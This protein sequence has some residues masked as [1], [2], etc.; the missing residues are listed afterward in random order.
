[1]SNDFLPGRALSAR[2]QTWVFVGVGGVSMCS[3]C[4]LAQRDGAHVVGSDRVPSAAT[5]HLRSL[6]I[7][8]YIGHSEENVPPDADAL[9]YSLAIPP[10]APERQAARRL[11][12]PEWS[13]AQFFGAYM[14]RFAERIGVSGTHGKSTVTAMLHHVFSCAGRSPTTLCGTEV[15]DPF[16]CCCGDDQY[17]IYEGCEYREALL[18]FCPTT[19]VLLNAEWDHPDCFADAQALVS[20]FLRAAEAAGRVVLSVDDRSLRAI[21][22]TMPSRAWTFGQSSDARL[23]YDVIGHTRGC[24][25]VDVTENGTHLGEIQLAVPGRFQC[26]NAAAAV[27]AARAYDVPFETIR[28]ALES[29]YGISRRL[30]P[31]TLACGRQVY[32]D[33]AH[34]P[35]EIRASIEAL[36]QMSDERLCVVFRPHTFSRTAALWDDFRRALSLAD[37]V[38]L[39]DIYAARETPIEGITAERLAQAIGERARYVPL[40]VLPSELMCVQGRVV[41]MGAGDLSVLTDGAQRPCS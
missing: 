23:R 15:T 39:T 9:I 17:L 28:E 20:V 10:D 34:H 4:M 33:Y 29:F 30:E 35:T 25:R 36:R 5:E 24:F 16:A 8:V 31:I 27:C 1:M 40:S 21:A 38:L 7:P 41:L 2:G 19:L 22:E 3:L 37:E 26:A 18:S 11:G 13:R 12:I 14:H 6:G 32:Y